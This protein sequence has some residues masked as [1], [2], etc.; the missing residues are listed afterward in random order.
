MS[1]N[2]RIGAT[3]NCGSRTPGDISVDNSHRR[4]F[5]L[6]SARA[7]GAYWGVGAETRFVVQLHDATTLHFDFRLQSV[8]SVARGRYLR[9]R[10][11]TRECGG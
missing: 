6:L 8:M 5:G 3:A 4:P 11:S 1:S 9:D 7:R 2:G 10:P